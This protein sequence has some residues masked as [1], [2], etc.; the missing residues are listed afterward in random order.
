MDD[1]IVNNLKM[2]IGSVPVNLKFFDRNELMTA[3]TCTLLHTGTA[4]IPLAATEQP[5]GPHSLPLGSIYAIFRL[6]LGS[7][8]AL[9]SRLKGSRET[10]WYPAASNS[11]M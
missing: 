1:K 2:V 3:G 4:K 7:P 5:T 6:H 8:K 11:P 9:I 10:F